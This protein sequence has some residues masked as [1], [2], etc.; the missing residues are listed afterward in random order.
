[1]PVDP[2]RSVPKEFEPWTVEEAQRM[3]LM[4]HS[5]I[6]MTMDV[7]AHVVDKSKREAINVIDELLKRKKGPSP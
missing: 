3:E 2:P 1:L 7:Y 4:G 6:S 5:K